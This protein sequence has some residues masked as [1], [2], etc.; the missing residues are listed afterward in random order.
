MTGSNKHEAGEVKEIPYMYS[1]EEA[2]LVLEV[3]KTKGVDPS[4]RT[5]RAAGVSV[6]KE[7]ISSLQNDEPVTLRIVK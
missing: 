7:P 3:L 6:V 2:R 1:P 4:E 5:L